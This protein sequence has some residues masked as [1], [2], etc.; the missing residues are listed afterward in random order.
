MKQKHKERTFTYILSLTQNT[1]T[2]L[3]EK[4]Q[5]R[6][7]NYLYL[8]KSSL[9]EELYNDYIKTKIEPK[10]SIR[11]LKRQRKQ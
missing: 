1:K 2:E 6:H 5:R 3:Q 8:N 4:C 9:I 11:P 7:L 10:Y